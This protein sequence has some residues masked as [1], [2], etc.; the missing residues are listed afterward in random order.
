MRPDAPQVPASVRRLLAV[1]RAALAAVLGGLAFVHLTQVVNYSQYYRG[2]LGPALAGAGFLV[3]A[4]LLFV[5][6]RLVRGS[7]A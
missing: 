1:L 4:G 5:P 7:A 2:I 3:L 6:S